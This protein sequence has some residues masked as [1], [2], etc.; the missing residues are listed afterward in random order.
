MH[1]P[2][3]SYDYGQECTENIGDVEGH[4][5]GGRSVTGMHYADDTRLLADS[6][7]K[8]PRIVV[9]V[10]EASEKRPGDKNKGN[11]RLRT[12]K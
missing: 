11:G 3:P 10:K 12:P 8:F 7:K 9:D 4:R 2:Q 1:F 5:R 6:E